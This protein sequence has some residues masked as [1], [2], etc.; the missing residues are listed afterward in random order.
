MTSVRVLFDK[1]TE[2]YPVAAAYL[3]SEANI[4]HSPAFERAVVK[5]YAK[6]AKMLDQACHCAQNTG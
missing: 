1:M 5:V 2:M 4:V 6:S 3:S